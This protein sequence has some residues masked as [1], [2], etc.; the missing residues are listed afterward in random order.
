MN[1][2][3]AKKKFKHQW[4]AFN[5]EKE[6]NDPEGEVVANYPTRH[7]LYKNLSQLEYPNLYITFTGPILH[8]FYK[9]QN[10]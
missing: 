10:N 8:R 4:L 6:G 2:S 3:S 1:L 5:I 7:E 9:L